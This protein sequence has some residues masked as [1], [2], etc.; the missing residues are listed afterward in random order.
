[1][2]GGLAFMNRGHMAVVA[3]GQGGL[4]VRVGADD[5]GALLQRDGV[6][7]VEM[8]NRPMTGWVRVD[9]ERLRTAR[10]LTGWVSRGMAFTDALPPKR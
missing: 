7:Q 8:R 10:Q 5:A 2:F 1:M 6:E 9:A 4:M 3:S